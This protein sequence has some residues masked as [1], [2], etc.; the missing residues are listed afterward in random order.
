MLTGFS[1]EM[2]LG[3]DHLRTVFQPIFRLS[4]GRPVE[5]GVEALTRGPAESHFANANVLFDYVR[6]KHA[7][8]RADRRCVSQALR[9]ALAIPEPLKI[10]LNVH[11]ATLDKDPEFPAWLAAE[12]RRNGVPPTRLI[13]ELVEQSQYW[14]LGRVHRAVEQVRRSGTS[15][16]L[17]DVGCGHCNYQMIVDLQPE[18]LKLDRYFVENCTTEPY[19]GAVIRSMQ[20]LAGD[21][22]SIVIAEGVETADELQTLQQ[23]GLS[24]AQGFMLGVPQSVGERTAGTQP[25]FSFA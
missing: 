23:F 17:D 16:A 4:D 6:L 19:R 9:Q 2:L 20:Q 18:Y 24:L 21:I 15:V 14:N 1:L 7:E 12:A 11:A 13:V 10:A 8:P 22:G 3:G 5:W 25:Q